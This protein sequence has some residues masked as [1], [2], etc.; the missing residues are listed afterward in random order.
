MRYLLLTALFL[1]GCG[2][3]TP[4][5]HTVCENG[6]CEERPIGCEPV[7]CLPDEEWDDHNCHC[8]LRGDA[9]LE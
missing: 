2:A 5:T 6:T 7:R 4:T 8:T 1:V 9:H 3:S